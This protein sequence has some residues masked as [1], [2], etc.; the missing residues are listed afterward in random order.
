MS[1]PPDETVILLRQWHAGDRQALEHLVARELPWIRNYVHGRL[2]QLLRAR[3]DTED[4]VQEAM[5]RVLCYGP[6]FATGSRRAFRRLLGRIVENSL[7]DQAD[8]HGAER[9]ALAKERPVPSDSVL[10]LDR[11]QES[12]TRP[13]EALA[14]KEQEAWVALALEL[15]DPD[16]RQVIRLRQ[17]EGLPF[18]DVAARLG[19]P[20]DTARMRFRRALPRLARKLEQLQSGAFG[21]GGDDESDDG[22]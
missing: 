6:R 9:R 16:D 21:D 14:R 18:A 19:L 1:S 5:L 13:S 7:R 2:G 11:P 3:G 12:V 15:L 4:Y 10:H 20:E 17:W 22:D 8:W